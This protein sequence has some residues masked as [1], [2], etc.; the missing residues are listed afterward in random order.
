MKKARAIIT[1]AEEA[2]VRVILE[3]FSEKVKDYVVQGAT[4]GTE[5]AVMNG[6]LLAVSAVV[7][8]VA[9]TLREFTGDPREWV[10]HDQ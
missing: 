8:A 2:E 7:E 4:S 6:V 10:N 3:I 5:F 9:D 1:P